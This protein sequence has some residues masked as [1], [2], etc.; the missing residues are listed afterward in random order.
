MT[1]M[2]G[3]RRR[4]LQ[5]HHLR[6]GL[7]QPQKMSSDEPPPQRRRRKESETK[8]PFLPLPPYR[9]PMWRKSQKRFERAPTAL[10]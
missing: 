7:N 10:P 1:M 4:T 3:P 8:A 2:S 6:R 5:C 9:M